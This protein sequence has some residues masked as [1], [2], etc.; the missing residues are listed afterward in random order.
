MSA[1]ETRTKI[2]MVLN[3]VNDRITTEDLLAH[4]MLKNEGLNLRNL[5]INLGL[6]KKEKLVRRYKDKTW[7]AHHL[8]ESTEVVTKPQPQMFF[9]LNP[10]EKT[11]SLDVGGIR[12]PVQIER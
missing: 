1:S 9:V 11:I 5:G 4:P 12:L 3:A 6:L 7:A 2:L 8:S 10:V